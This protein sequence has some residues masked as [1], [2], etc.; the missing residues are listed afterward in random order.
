MGV[1][2]PMP[3]PLQGGDM[4]R[5]KQEHELCGCIFCCSKCPEC[6]DTDIEIVYRPEFVLSNDIEDQL[7]FLV[8][9]TD[10]ELNC[11]GCGV[12]LSDKDERLYPLKNALWETLGIGSHLQEIKHGK[13]KGTSYICKEAHH[14][15]PHKKRKGKRSAPA[16]R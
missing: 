7:H 15:R 14:S 10:I 12:S 9:G 11:N 4:G 6:G 1:I 13:I 16:E 5:K 3:G 8:R 2:V